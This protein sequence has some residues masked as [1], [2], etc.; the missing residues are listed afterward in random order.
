MKAIN[1]LTKC[2][3]ILYMFEH[4]IPVQV[5]HNTL[6]CKEGNMGCSTVS[7]LLFVILRYFHLLNGNN[8]IICMCEEEIT[9]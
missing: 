4:V 8:L 2:R 1:C 3:I 5:D 7:S 9:V 6:H